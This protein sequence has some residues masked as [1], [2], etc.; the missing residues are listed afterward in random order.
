MFLAAFMSSS[1]LLSTLLIILG[2]IYACRKEDPQSQVYSLLGFFIVVFTLLILPLGLLGCEKASTKPASPP[3]KVEIPVSEAV[4]SIAGS[5]LTVTVDVPKGGRVGE[6][7]VQFSGALYEGS[8][9]DA[10][11]GW[12]RAQDMWGL[13]WSVKVEGNALILSPATHKDDLVEGTWTVHISWYKG[14]QLP[15]L[16]SVEVK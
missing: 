7:V 13:T 9:S 10:C 4:A 12:Y 8:M 5:Q 3:T 1:Q 11:G 16:H 15:Q 6:V 14:T 2:I